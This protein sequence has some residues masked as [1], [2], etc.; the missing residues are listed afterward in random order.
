[1]KP[2]IVLGIAFVLA[3]AGTRYTLGH[4]DYHLSGRIAIAVMLV[5]TG[6]A[7]FVYTR[8]MAMML[9]DIVAFRRVLVILTGLIEITAP[10]GLLIPSFTRD[11]GLLL[12]LFFLLLLPANIYAAM[13]R[14]DYQTSSHDGYGAS[15][16]WIRVPLQLFFIIWVYLVAVHR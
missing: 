7:H 11:T 16:L 3:L 13:H 15:Y 6:I 12:M 5:F 14:I 2:L 1:M 9:P 4:I 10:I 8:G